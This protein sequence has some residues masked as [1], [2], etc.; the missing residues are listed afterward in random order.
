MPFWE[1]CAR[2]LL[3]SQR[4]HRNSST[5]NQQARLQ[6]KD[7]KSSNNNQQDRSTLLV[8]VNSKV[9]RHSLRRRKGVDHRQQR[10]WGSMSVQRQQRTRG[11]DREKAENAGT[12]ER[13][14]DR[15]TTGL[16]S[17]HTIILL[18]DSEGSFLPCVQVQLSIDIRGPTPL[19]RRKSHLFLWIP[20]EQRTWQGQ[21][22]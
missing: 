4:K 3:A 8:A 10:T 14:H 11:V 12:L 18:T 2:R 19:N 7:P 6:R 17:L 15:D 20:P 21:E 13:Y 16:S 1:S 9:V 22:Q 5:R